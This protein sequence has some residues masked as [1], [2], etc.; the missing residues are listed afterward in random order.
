[1]TI[2]A[3]MIE[4][5]NLLHS[6]DAFVTLAKLGVL[7]GPN[8]YWAC[9]ISKEIIWNGQVWEPVAVQIGMIR[10]SKEE[11]PQ[12]DIAISNINKV[13]ETYAQDYDGLIGSMLY[14]YEVN[15]F[16]L[17]VTANIPEYKLEIVDASFSI[18]WANFTLGVKPN[19]FNVRDPKDKMT[20]N[21]CR[22]GYKNSVDKRC[23]YTGDVYASCN[24]TLEHCIQRNGAAGSIRF[25]GFP[26]IGT[27]KIYVS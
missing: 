7:D 27:N 23:P 25:G 17:T 9:N 16:D 18:M 3:K 2:N 22:Y 6:S 10:S 14:F 5:K 12:V 1:M 4:A 8:L 15:T 19:P 21:F 20:K 11:V 26:A 13:P 24:R